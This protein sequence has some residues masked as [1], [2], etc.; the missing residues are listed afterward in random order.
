MKPTLTL[1]IVTVVVMKSYATT[2]VLNGRDTFPLP[3][4]KVITTGG[5]II[6]GE[7]QYVT[8]SSVYIL[9]GTNREIRKGFRYE[10]VEIPYAD[11]ISIRNKEANWVGL[12]LS[13][14][15]M[16]VIYLMLTGAIPVFNNGL[17]DANFLIWLSPLLFGYSLYRMFRK[18]RYVINGKKERFDK[19]RIWHHNAN[20]RDRKR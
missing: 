12:V 15:G 4:V 6:I 17:G 1:A 16:T 11:I 5:K 19:F 8:D 3:F 9:P 20:M 13:L 7:L 18:K 14:A 2:T 10:Q